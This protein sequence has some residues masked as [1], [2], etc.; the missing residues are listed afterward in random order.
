MCASNF[1]HEELAHINRITFRMIFRFCKCR[2]RSEILSE[3]ND[4]LCWTNHQRARAML[5]MPPDGT[6]TSGWFDKR[7]IFFF[8]A[9]F[10]CI[11]ESVSVKMKR[12]RAY[13]HKKKYMAQIG[14][15]EDLRT[16]KKTVEH[17]LSLHHHHQ[18]SPSSSSSSSLR[19]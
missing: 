1:P 18:L 4:S 13:T 11:S 6:W 3:L 5:T 12:C 8:G 16:R 7:R 17:A 9:R 19:V 10:V 15:L 2:R 14:A